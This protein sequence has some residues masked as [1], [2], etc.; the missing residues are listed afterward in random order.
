MPDQVFTSQPMTPE[1]QSNNKT[2]IIVFSVLVAFLLA[3]V[4]AL[5]YQNWQLNQKL[6]AATEETITLPTPSPATLATPDPTSNWQTYDNVNAGISFKHPVE[7]SEQSVMVSGPILGSTNY[8]TSFADKTTVIP[9]TD[10]PFNGF[11]VYE[12]FADQLGM[13]FD[14]YI[15][16]EVE[17]VK[18]S[19]RGIKNASAVKTTI[20]G[21]IFTYIDSEQNIRRYFI[22]SPLNNRIAIFSRVNSTPEFVTI[23][24]QILSTFKFTN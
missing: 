16:Q 4:A 22:L 11:S 13:S 24:D 2:L 8:V 3:S 20:G 14:T 21:Q 1:P 18:T 23:F 10:A 17:A 5:A 12:I 15:A 9:N 7:I 19:E 6:A